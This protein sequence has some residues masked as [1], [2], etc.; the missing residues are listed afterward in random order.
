MA[1]S[2]PHALVLDGGLVERVVAFHGHMCPGLAMGI[3]AARLALREVGPHATD[4]EV[5]AIT[6]TD[7]CGVDAIQVLTGCTFGKGN[8]IH[9]DYGK[10]AYTFIR[11]SD[12]RAVRVVVRPGAWT[13]DPEHQRL[14]TLVR[15]GEASTQERVR[16]RELHVAASAAILELEPEELYATQEVVA[17]P[18]RKARIHASMTCANCGEEAMETRIRRFDGNDLCQLCFE[19]LAVSDPVTIT[20]LSWRE[21]GVPAR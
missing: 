20:D 9:H 16:F 2:T 11:R 10:N 18:P 8:L 12:G 15:S 3:Q 1:G 17:R 6:E 4:E 13:R 21:P 14:S 5:V 19:A 7:M